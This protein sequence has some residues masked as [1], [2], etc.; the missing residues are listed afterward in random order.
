[1]TPTLHHFFVSGRVF[2]DAARSALDRHSRPGRNGLGP[3]RAALDAYPLGSKPPD[4]VLEGWWRS[5]G[6]RV[7]TIV[8]DPAPDV[9]VAL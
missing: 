2:P 1:V 7:V 9:P 8:A 5:D 3:L 4:S 6:E